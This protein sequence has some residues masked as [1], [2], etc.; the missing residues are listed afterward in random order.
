[1]DSPFSHLHGTN[2]IPSGPELEELTALTLPEDSRLIELEKEIKGLTSLLEKTTKE[3][4]AVLKKIRPIKALTSLIRRLPT[5]ILQLIFLHARIPPAPD[6]TTFRACDTPFT[7]LRVCRSWREIAENTPQLWS[8]FNVSLPQQLVDR[9]DPS[10]IA[11]FIDEVRRWLKRSGDVPLRIT[12]SKDSDST[13]RAQ[14]LSREALNSAFRVV[15]EQCRRWEALDVE[16]CEATMKLLA[17]LTADSTPLLKSLKIREYKWYNANT[18]LFRCTALLSAPHLE[19]LHVWSNDPLVHK[20]SDAPVKWANLTSLSLGNTYVQHPLHVG[21]NAPAPPPLNHALLPVLEKCVNL[22]SLLVTLPPTKL[23][24][25]LHGVTLQKL[26]SLNLGGCSTQI[27]LLLKNII[28]PSL[29]EMHYYPHYEISK[30]E[31]LPFLKFIEQQGGRLEVL[32][33]DAP[34]FTA[35]H[36]TSCLKAIPSVKQLMIGRQLLNPFASRSIGPYPHLNHDDPYHFTDAHLAILTPP[37]C[38]P[39]LEILRILIKCQ[40]SPKAVIAFLEAKTDPSIVKHGQGSRIREV[41]L[42]EL[43]DTF[44]LLSY[45]YPQN[46]WGDDMEDILSSF[47]EKG[48][49]LS[50]SL[51]DYHCPTRYLPP[52]QHLYSYDSDFGSAPLG[53]PR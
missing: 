25:P 30:H 29:R 52:I 28:T 14:L 17:D 49:E 11:S 40:L 6:T 21:M 12:V 3:K 9:Q 15:V 42:E 33:F 38:C 51:T 5:E 4:A 1:M 26:R 24:R 46:P 8:T 50:L 27:D 44:P 31:P 43:P 19:K 13:D 48:V 36:L 45:R 34:S 37:G 35:E 23:S 41:S 32:C 7:L 47:K 20:L 10:K 16:L 39:S 53:A 22:R 2:L 18:S